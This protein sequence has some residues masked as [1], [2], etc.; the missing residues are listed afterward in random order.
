[1][2]FLWN[3]KRDEATSEDASDT[4]SD[5]PVENDSDRGETASET[6]VSEVTESTE[7][8]SAVS[9]NDASAEDALDATAHSSVENNGD[10]VSPEKDEPPA[11]QTDDLSEVN[12]NIAE[13]RQLFEDQIQDQN[14]KFEK[15]YRDL[16]KYKAHFLEDLHKTV[17]P[18]L[19]LR[20][21][22]PSKI[23]VVEETAPSVPE[24]EP[25]ALQ[26]D[27]LAEVNQN[28]AE[29]RQ[30]FEDQIARNAN[31]NKMFDAIHREMK[32]YKENSLLEALHKP[33]IHN[34]IGFYDN[35]TL[36]ESQLNDILNE[37]E[38]IRLDD[39]SQFQ[40]NLENIRFELEEVLYR[41]DVTPYEERRET[42]DQKLHKTLDTKPADTPEQD[43]KVAE[44][45]KIG[46]HWREKVFRPGR[47]DDLSIYTIPDRKRRRNRWVKLLE[48]TWER[49]SLQ[50]RMSMN[51]AQPEIVPNAESDRIT[52][53]VI[54]F[55]DELV[56][57]G[58]I[59]KPER[60]SGA[61]SDR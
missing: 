44:V 18:N 48:L 21:E 40:K 61:R 16:E 32:D 56:T 23:D 39:L 26:T 58:K 49:H 25:P 17:S 8:E 60:R 50:S 45:H 47:G 11:L 2:G 34:L 55:E 51:I 59:A 30:L 33:I 57:V 10:E 24:D 14:N 13:L 3:R 12:Q 46:F 27:G 7:D 42:L 22:T 6:V 43:G 31:Q 38:D 54:M 41:L 15:L 37:T 5:S 29:L 9:Q 35:F 20:V 19:T 1:M 52:P 28:I 53:S 36:I 4:A